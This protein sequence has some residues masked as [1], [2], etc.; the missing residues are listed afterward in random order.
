MASAVPVYQACAFRRGIGLEYAD[1]ALR[2][3]QVPRFADAQVVLEAVR[4]ILGQNPNRGDAGMYAV[5]EREIDDA[6][7]AR[8]RNRGLGPLVRQGHQPGSGTAGQN[9]CQGLDVNRSLQVGVG[10]RVTL[11]TK[12]CPILQCQVTWA[13]QSHSNLGG[14]G[15]G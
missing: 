14:G 11:W 13:G 12:G 3:V 10:H 9:H 4:L 8:E 5:A 15:R 7:L 1:S 6:K 2:A